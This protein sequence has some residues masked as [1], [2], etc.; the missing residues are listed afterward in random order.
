MRVRVLMEEG[1]GPAAFGVG[2]SYGTTSFDDI[3]RANV[4]KAERFSTDLSSVLR[5]LYNKDDGHNKFLESITVWLAIE[6]TRAFWQEFD[7][8][9]VGITKQS[10]STIHTL[11]KRELKQADCAEGTHSK[12]IDTVNFYIIHAQQRK[13]DKDIDGYN[14]YMRVAKLNLPEG[15]LQTR[16]VCTNY[17]KLRDI[18]KQRDKHRLKD[19]RN[20][21]DAVV[22]QVEIPEFLTQTKEEK[23]KGE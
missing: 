7:T 17:K 6:A 12:V 13:A 9:R 5:K 14:H 8:Y 19:W 1:L 23:K 21:I 15:F 18:I 11:T 2:L 16:M 10:E 22:E 3:D 20:F 4:M